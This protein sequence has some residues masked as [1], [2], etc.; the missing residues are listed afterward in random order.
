MD[1]PYNLQRFVD[2]QAPVIDRVRDELAQGRKRSHWMWFVFPQIAGLGR[3][4]TAQRYA[5][6]SL[7]EA[8]A[9]GEHPLLGARLLECAGVLME[10]VDRTASEIFGPVD[11]IKLRSSMTLFMRAMPE[12]PIFG[13][14]LTRYFEGMPDTETN[15]LLD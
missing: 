8:R 7:Q 15:R 3:S 12:E 14:V 10:L 13:E 9:Y 2:A 1:D 4:A 5:L 11:S 6:T